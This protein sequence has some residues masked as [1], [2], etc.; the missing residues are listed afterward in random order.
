MRNFLRIPVVIF[1]LNSYD[2]PSEPR[3]E[4]GA[5]FGV[6]VVVLMCGTRQYVVRKCKPFTKCFRNQQG[7]NM[8]HDIVAS[9]HVQRGKRLFRVVRDGFSGYWK[10]R[11]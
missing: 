10:L 6:L 9:I 2:I 3:Q 7:R 11:N 4:V 5:V 1:T 8:F